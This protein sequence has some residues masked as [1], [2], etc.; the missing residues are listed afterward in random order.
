MGAETA[1]PG[2]RIVFEAKEDKSYTSKRVRD[3]LQTSRSNRQAQVGVFV[4]SK[5]SA[6]EGTEPLCREGSDI[7]VIW[8]PE[9]AA[10][11]VNVKAA[12]SLAR[13]MVVQEKKSS[14]NTAADIT[15]IESGTAA[16]TRDLSLLDEIGTWAN[17]VKNNGEKIGSKASLMRKRIEE[18]LATL[19]EHVSGLRALCSS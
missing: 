6:P 12:I 2:S 11:D 7:I 1:A 5:T 4:W 16:I 8:D 18:Q 14:D 17:T 3:D 10:T 19:T 9:D 15:A 13:L